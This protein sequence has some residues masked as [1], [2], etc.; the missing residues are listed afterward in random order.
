[1]RVC[2]PP[3]TKK[4]SRPKPV[5]LLGSR[6]ESITQKAGRAR[7]KRKNQ[8]IFFLNK[9]LIFSYLKSKLLI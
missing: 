5:A 8:K 4:A 2:A 1:M 3:P 6:C 7:R 9:Y